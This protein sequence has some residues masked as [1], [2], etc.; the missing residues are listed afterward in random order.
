MIRP[1]IPKIV[2]D[3]A[4]DPAKLEKV[5]IIV[6]DFMTFDYM[7][8]NEILSLNLLKDIVK[9]ELKEEFRKAIGK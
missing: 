9:E 4:A 6:G 3:I 7:K 5:N 8:S 1:F 2:A